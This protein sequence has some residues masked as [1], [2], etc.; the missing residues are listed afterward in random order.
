M[1]YW[2]LESQHAS[3]PVPSGPAGF[4]C[5]VVLLT[6]QGT[7][8]LPV[9]A[10]H[11]LACPL[12]AVQRELSNAHPVIFPTSPSQGMDL[13]PVSTHNNTPRPHSIKFMSSLQSSLW[14]IRWQL[15]LWHSPPLTPA[16]SAPSAVAP[17]SS[18]P[19][20][21]TCFCL[22]VFAVPS[23]KS[24]LPFMSAVV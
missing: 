1:D 13:Q 6:R 22:F 24:L 19:K 21:L 12:R 8:W 17:S 2:L 11:C 14:P 5:Q 10:P 23:A 16:H 9:V 3:W 15:A 18:F 20:V 4:P 7:R